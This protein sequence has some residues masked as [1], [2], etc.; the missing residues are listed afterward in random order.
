MVR[1]NRRVLR[2]DVERLD[3]RCL[4][5]IASVPAGYTPAQVKAAYG[6]DAIRF[7]STNGQPLPGDG[8]GQTIAIVVAYHDPY[9]ASDLRRFDAAFGL[10]DPAFSQ[11]NLG[12]SGNISDSWSGEATLDVEWAHAIAPGASI[13]VVETASDSSA[14]LLAGVNTAR[15]LPGVSVVS[16]SWGGPEMANEASDDLYFTTP[17]GHQGITFIAASG[18]TGTGSTQWPAS[19]PNVLG[20]GGTSLMI[21]GSGYGGESAWTGGGSGLSRYQAE[22]AYQ[23]GV[24]STGRRS[25]PDVAF[26]G[27]PN[28]GV[29]IYMTTP[30]NGQGSW[31]I[32]GG[33][34]LGAP[35]WAGIVA[36]IDEGLVLNG[37]GTLDGA[38]RL[39]PALYTLPATD[40]HA[41]APT[42]RAGARGV[43]T[44]GLGTPVGA[45][46]V[47]NVVRLATPVQQAPVAATTPATTPASSPTK[48]NSG[49]AWPIFNGGG[50]AGTVGSTPT[51]GRAKPPP[52]KAPV[53]H[54]T[55]PKKTTPR[56]RH[57][58]TAIAVL[59]EL[60]SRFEPLEHAIHDLAAGLR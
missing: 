54:R 36:I 42:A 24:Q 59:S 6:L 55:P 28:T 1:R 48:P 13:L 14:D 4:L 10:P 44:T 25:I 56:A 58:A 5:S 3:D 8:Q 45:S 46:L 53:V 49:S 11:I 16:M 21:N 51:K 32:V 34:S 20:V 57:A 7:T 19:S 23:R 50:F 37:V 2:P 35:A 41:V 9:L 52:K 40:F 43:S 27:N 17:V 18:D 39:I 22:P 12:G 30:S 60:P 38:S 47:A 33:T 15:N 26:V 29:S 31:Q